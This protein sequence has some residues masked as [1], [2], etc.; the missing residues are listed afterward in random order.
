[1]DGSNGSPCHG[2]I[3]VFFGQLVVVW[4]NNYESSF[5]SQCVS[6]MGKCMPSFDSRGLPYEDMSLQ[7]RL[8][9][10]L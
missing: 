1:M 2:Q 7:L 6:G 4:G 3:C 9:L 5:G 8:G 10:S